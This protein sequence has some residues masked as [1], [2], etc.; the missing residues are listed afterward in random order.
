MDFNW[1]HLG[2]SALLPLTLIS[3]LLLGSNLIQF[4]ACVSNSQGRPFTKNTL[5]WNISRAKIT[6]AFIFAVLQLECVKSCV[7]VCVIF[8]LIYLILTALNNYT[9][10][11]TY[12]SQRLRLPD[13][14]SLALYIRQIQMILW[15][16]IFVCLAKYMRKSSDLLNCVFSVLSGHPST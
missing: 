2:I 6:T 14:K 3:E 4:S 1:H 7:C 12:C 8:S 13:K 15:V 16:N 11:L 9:E 5:S 10:D